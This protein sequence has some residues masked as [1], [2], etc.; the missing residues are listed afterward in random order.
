M[1]VDLDW[2]L[3]ASNMSAS[4]ELLVYIRVGKRYI[5]LWRSQRSRTVVWGGLRWDGS[6][7]RP[8]G[9]GATP[10]AA[11]GAGAGTADTSPARK[12]NPKVE[13]ATSVGVILPETGQFLLLC[14]LQLWQQLHRCRQTRTRV[15][16]FLRILLPF[17]GNS[18]R[19]ERHVSQGSEQLQ[20]SARV[21]KVAAD[22][23]SNHSHI[24]LFLVDSMPRFCS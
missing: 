13:A 7:K 11:A 1:F 17:Y 4:A 20:P 19:R 10:T 2:P 18:V 3:N 22:A 21:K 23:A 5:R 15:Q 9:A 24:A 14:S 12:P 6:W 16:V 8:A